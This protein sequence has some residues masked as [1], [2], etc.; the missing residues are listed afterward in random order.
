MLSKLDTAM[1][2]E[3]RNVLLLATAQALF[4]SVMVLMITASGIVGMQLAPNAHLATLPAAM[5]LLA[6]TITMIPASLLMQRLGRKVG[7]LAGA[8]LGCLG[9]VVAMFAIHAQDFWLF[10]GASM[11][12]GA[13]SGFAGYYR[14]A[15]ADIASDAFR[16]RAISWVVAGGVVAAVA[17]TNIVRVTQNIG[18]TQFLFT[19]MALTVL[20][21]AALFVISRL[22]LPAPA[23]SHTGGA[24]RPLGTIIRQPVYIAAVICSTVG[25]SM[26]SLVMTATPLAMLMCGY[27]VGDSATVIQWHV[28]GM[29]VPSFFTGTLIQ[30]FGVMKIVTLGIVL[31]GGHVAIAI[32]GIEFLRFVSGLTLLGVGW[33]FLFVG[34]TT[35]LTQ[36]YRPAE[37]A[38]TQAA[39]DFMMMTVVS[40]ASFSA[41]GL[42]N[43]WGWNTV[44]LTVL[45]F[46]ILAAASIGGLA[47]VKR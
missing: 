21:I 13:Y 1:T 25:F 41:G 30:R 4:Q 35:L 3:K 39:H 24:A 7:F 2:P 11:L 10:I 19:Y 23:T 17:G 37:R 22:S 40:I 29:F 12:V 15:A 14:F 31:L 47:I 28:L 16:S 45:P 42:L 8:G 34:G 38:K 20:G 32:T 36:A 27:T 46:L 33:N 18:A 44:N 26:M 9:G 6:A 43:A 5:V